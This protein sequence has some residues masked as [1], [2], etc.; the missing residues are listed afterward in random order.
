[1]GFYDGIEKEDA[2]TDRGAFVRAGR[3]LAL[4]NRVRSGHSDK[5]T[6]DYVAIDMTILHDFG[7]GEK[8][9]IV[10]PETNNLKDWIEDPKGFHRAGE[11]VSVQ[12]MGKHKSAKRN[13]KAFIANA[14]GVPE[15]QV[16]P[17][18]CAQ[19]E[20]DELLSGEVIE[21][22]NRM[23][24]L[25]SGGPFTKVWAVRPVPASEFSKVLD[26]KVISRFYPDGLDVLIAA[27]T[28]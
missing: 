21:L 23:I 15:G 11:D 19:V 5:H 9:V 4:I 8:S 1:M 16:D 17:A 3:Y 14:V 2:A 24:E 26:E 25:K 7:D 13:Y 27:E 22:N 12:F 20:S 28:D 18:F 10:N 6:C